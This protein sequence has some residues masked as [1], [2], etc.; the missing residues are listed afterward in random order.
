MTNDWLKMLGMVLALAVSLPFALL[1]C[2]NQSGQGEAD[3]VTLAK[4]QYDEQ[5]NFCHGPGR[6][7]DVETVH[8]S[9][10]DTIDASITG[11]T[12]T[13][14]LATVNFQIHD[15][16]NQLIPI[17]GM[18]AGSVRFALVKLNPATG[19]WQSY[20][21]TTETKSAGDPGSAPDGTTVVQATYETG[22]TDGGVFTDNGDGTYSYQFSFNLATVSSPMAV[23]YEP[24][25]TH[26][27]AIQISGNK[28]NPYRDFVPDG[29]TVTDTRNIVMNASCNEC[30]IKLGFH[31]GDRIAVDYCVTCHNQGTS[32]ANSGNSVDFGVMIHKIHR[33]VNLH[34]VESGG[35]YAIWGYQNSKHDYSEVVY[36]QDIR[37]CTKCHTGAAGDENATADGDNWKQK[38]TMSSCGSCHD[39]V[40]FAAT[41]P[42][43]FVAHSGGPQTDNNSCVTCHPA[44]N[45]TAGVVG[46]HE[47]PEQV[48]AAKFKYN[49]ISIAN[50]APGSYPMI[51]FSVTDPTNSDAAYD[52]MSDPAF[53]AGGGV[54]RLAVLIGWDAAEHDNTGSSFTPGQPVSINPLASGMATA[55]GDGTFSVTSPIPIPADVTGSGVV[56]MEGH[57]AAESDSGEYTLRVPVT[58]VVQYFAITDAAPKPRRTVVD[59]A[60]CRQC[61]GMLSLHGANRNNETQLCVICH[62]PEATDINRRPANI[63][64]TTDG[65]T[66]ETVDFK[67][68]IHA[69]HGAQMR[70]DGIVVYGFGNQEHDF[71]HVE[72]PAGSDNNRNCAGCHATSTYQLPLA[73][74]VAPTTIKTGADLSTPDDD[75]N[76]TPATA[77]CSSCHENLAAKT[78]MSSQGGKFDFVPFAAET[79]VDEAALEC[80]PGV[81]S[82]QPVGHTQ[83]TSCCACHG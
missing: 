7:V 56:G 3:K 60:D 9:T 80:A 50:T 38:P 41:V 17:T 72:M 47:I 13:D 24:T 70:E 33:G 74:A 63:A 76:L 73:A 77:A 78:H 45:G 82:A 43:G 5:C 81:V 64:A 54:S 25:A 75:T 79:T 55:N 30:H 26:R 22:R 83:D 23:T 49:I 61:H 31:G 15:S 20:I 69:I 2:T 28:T 36:P 34:A 59:T 10:A 21:N 27:V 39:G 35:E 19:E 14:G 67:Y 42:E 62:N 4:Q 51:T 37:N 12:V 18:S 29:S 53:T 11:V 52:I 57:P 32:D 68:M 46:S 44:D 16:K 8:Q 40:S 48:A 71:S 6:T 66:E 58:S 1:S 65:K